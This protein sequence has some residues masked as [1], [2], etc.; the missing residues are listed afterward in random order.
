[1]PFVRT[2]TNQTITAEQERQLKG[3]LSMYARGDGSRPIA[4]IEVAV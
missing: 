4:Y 2:K 1:M 3:G